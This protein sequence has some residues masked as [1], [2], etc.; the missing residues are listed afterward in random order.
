MRAKRKAWSYDS[1]SR[2]L[3]KL[4]ILK[5][6]KIKNPIYFE[7][8]QNNKCVLGDF[9]KVCSCKMIFNSQQIVILFYESIGG[10]LLRE[11]GGYCTQ[12]RYET[13][14]QKTECICTGVAQGARGLPRFFFPSGNDDR[15]NARVFSD[16]VA[17][18]VFVL[19]DAPVRRN[20]YRA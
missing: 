9:L 13:G 8:Y 5:N 4:I 7:D 15:R 6:I 19:A 12:C 20:A 11:K 17:C 2:F 3:P 18:A 1:L 10:R 14:G 16:H